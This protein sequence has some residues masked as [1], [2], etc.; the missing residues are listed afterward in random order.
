M[1]T[2]IGIAGNK[3]QTN[4]VGR[5][6][7][8]KRMLHLIQ[9]HV[10]SFRLF[11]VHAMIFIIVSTGSLLIKGTGSAFMWSLAGWGVGLALHAIAIYSPNGNGFDERIN[12]NPVE[13][14]TILASPRIGVH[15]Q[16]TNMDFDAVWRLNV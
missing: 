2:D 3:T 9:Q 15:Q 10:R 5:H 13:G 1:S 4:N 16:S 12:A 11:Y 14:E 7:L 8:N 6:A